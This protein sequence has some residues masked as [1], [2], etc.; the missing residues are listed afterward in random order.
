MSEMRA[1]PQRGDAR[2]RV[3]ATSEPPNIADLRK[4]D[5]RRVLFRPLAAA[6]SVFK[7]LN[8]VK[9]VDER[10]RATKPG[11]ARPVSVTARRRIASPFGEERY[12]YGK[13]HRKGHGGR[14]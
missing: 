8:P 3:M 9:A 1:P 12:S 4:I 10:S 2:E 13:E 7:R 6:F 14:P 5:T 11:V